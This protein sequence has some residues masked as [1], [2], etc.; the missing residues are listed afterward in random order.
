M[1]LVGGMAM[2]FLGWKVARWE[3][4]MRR[5]WLHQ[6]V[7]FSGGVRRE[8]AN[9]VTLFTSVVSLC[10]TSRFERTRCTLR[11]PS[12]LVIKVTN[13]FS[14][15]PLPH[16]TAFLSCRRLILHSPRRRLLL[17]TLLILSPVPTDPSTPSSPSPCLHP[18]S[19]QWAHTS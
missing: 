13:T 8:W 7:L 5:W 3:P 14:P 4:W 1:A 9:C 18:P 11:F 16:A 15:L 2:V 12:L 6:P 19:S 17:P 10:P